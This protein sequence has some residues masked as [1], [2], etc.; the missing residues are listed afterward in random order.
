MVSSAQ[1]EQQKELKKIRRQPVPSVYCPPVP[2]RQSKMIKKDPDVCWEFNSKAG[3]KNSQCQW[4]HIKYPTYSLQRSGKRENGKSKGSSS[5]R[6]KDDN[7][8]KPF[9]KETD[10]M[11]K[12]IEDNKRLGMGHKYGADS[13]GK[14][15]T[16]DKSKRRKEKVDQRKKGQRYEEALRIRAK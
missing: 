8:F 11:K 5:G 16:K 9:G 6:G 3:C 12:V 4:K 10:I 1:M 14:N 7:G 15:E 13:N 2:S